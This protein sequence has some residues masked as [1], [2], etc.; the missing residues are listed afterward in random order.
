[1]LLGLYKYKKIFFGVALGFFLAILSGFYAKSSQLQYTPTQRVVLIG[2]VSNL[3]TH[4]NDNSKFSFKVENHTINN[5]LVSWYNNTQSLEAGQRWQ[6]ELKLKP[7]HGYRN[8]GSFDYSK[9][10]FR[11]G[12]DATATVKS[13]KL[14]T[15]NTVSLS[16]FINNLRAKIAG[17]VDENFD[18]TRVKGLIQALTIGDK[19]LI[20][21]SDSQ[22]FQQT[23]T[24]HLIAISGL[25]IGLIAFVGILLGRLCFNVF[26]HENFNRSN[27]E[28]LFAIVFALIYA[29][30]AGL[31]IPTIRA[32]VMVAVFSLSYVFKQQVNRW[33]AWSI[34]MLI[35]L[36]FDPFSVL[37][38]GFWFSFGAVAVLMFTFTGRIYNNTLF[39]SFIKAQLVILVG[40]MPMMV[41]VFQKVNLLTPIANLFALPLASILLIP[42]LFLSLFF[43]LFSKTLAEFLF[44]IVEELSLSLFSILDYLQQYAFLSITP[45]NITS[46]TLI[47]LVLVTVFLLLPRLFRWRYVALFLLIPLFTV[48]QNKFLENEFQVNVLDVGQGLAVII[49]SR[50]HLLIYDVGAKFESGFSLANSV[51]LP[52]LLN[53]GVTS[54]DTIVISH[55][56]NDHAG[57]IDDIIDSYSD[58]TLLGV[59]NKQGCVYP[60]SW[61]W[62][63]VDFM[64]LSP[65]SNYPYLKNNSSCV[66]KISSSYGSILLTGDIEEPVEYRL[67]NKFPKLISNDVLVIPHHGSRTSSSAG[68]V[69]HVNPRIAINSSGFANQFNHPHPVIKQRYVDN[70]IQF[71]DTQEEGMIEIKFASNGIKVESYKE[72]NRHFWYVN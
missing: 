18:S 1:M 72:E 16:S 23:G 26:A 63:G 62:D 27:Y 2:V 61:N 22:L 3:P 44:S 21:F 4:K 64:V 19:S 8:I 25:H 65:L 31:S 71:Y 50:N 10:L 29:S 60:K 70:K 38:I 69:K 28:A 6:L 59:R 52:Y 68:F 30:L 55:S 24:S 11:N 51:I 39:V 48:K 13:A 32:L 40:L 66:I 9:W 14:L 46:Y 42:L 49:K 54:V 7:I 36:T 17:L 20:E 53:Q 67:V 45:H 41:I 12:Y 57:G 33:Q 5:V 34:A 47:L 35:V 43:S 37:D 58:S 15:T 56:D